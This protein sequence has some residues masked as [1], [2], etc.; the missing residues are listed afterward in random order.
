[1]EKRCWD[2][3]PDCIAKK[4]TKC[5]VYNSEINCWEYDWVT[6]L[7]TMSEDEQ[8][9]WKEYML[10]KCPQCG[11]FMPQMNK[12]LERVKSEL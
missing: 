8:K 6:V 1:M 4:G 10:E 12:T 9:T 3:N 5:P 7:K 2:L 11:A